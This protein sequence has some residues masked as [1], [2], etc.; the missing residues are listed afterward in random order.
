MRYRRFQAPG[1][2]MPS[3]RQGFTA[4]HRDRT[5]KAPGQFHTIR[6]GKI[7]VI[8]GIDPAIETSSGTDRT[9]R[10][11]PAQAIPVRFLL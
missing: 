2:Y 10:H 5:G 4:F 8:P 11:D 6:A 3:I 7:G 1:A 9:L